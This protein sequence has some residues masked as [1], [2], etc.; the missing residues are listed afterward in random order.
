M[1][2]NQLNGKVQT[3][4]KNVCKKCKCMTFLFDERLENF[5]RRNKD[6]EKKAPRDKKITL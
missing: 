3:G 4:K 1:A 6:Q 5:W 2:R